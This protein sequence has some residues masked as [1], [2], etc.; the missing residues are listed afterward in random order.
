M[1][2]WRDR[3]TVMDLLE[4]F[5]GNRVNYSVNVLGGVKYDMTWISPIRSARGLISWRSAPTITWMWSPKTPRSCSA[6]ADRRDNPSRGRTAWSNWSD[7][8][9]IWCR[10]RYSR[11][12]AIWLLP[13]FSVS[14]VRESA[15]DLEAKFIVRINELFVT[16]QAI[17]VILDNLPE[18]N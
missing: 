7:C 18:A 2:S 4:T 17:Q 3:E 13:E 5:T 6:R 10:A 16:Y 11:R 15:G 1:Y 12:S 8:A 9:C 14:S